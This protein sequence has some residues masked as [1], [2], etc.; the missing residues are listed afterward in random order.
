VIC[1]VSGPSQKIIKTSR[2]GAQNAKKYGFSEKEPS[3]QNPGLIALKKEAASRKYE[4][5]VPFSPERPFQESLDFIEKM[6]A[7]KF[8]GS[9][10]LTVVKKT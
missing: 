4:V 10:R 1:Y 5:Y 8:F 7:S 9:E 2:S 6:V 3:S